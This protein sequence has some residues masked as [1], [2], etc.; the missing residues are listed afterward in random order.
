MRRENCGKVEADVEF[1]LAFCGKLSCSAE[2][3]C[4]KS[5]GDTQSTQSARFGKRICCRL[6]SVG[7]HDQQKGFEFRWI[8]KRGR[9]QEVRRRLLQMN[10]EATVYVI[11]LGKIL[12]NASPQGCASSFIA[13]KDFRWTRILIW[14]NQWSKNHISIKRDSNT[15]QHGELRF[16]SWGPGLSA[17]F[18]SI[19]SSSTPMTLLGQ[20]IDHSKSSSSSSTSTT[21]TSSKE[22]DHS[23]HFQ[24]SCQAIVWIDKNGETRILLKHQKSCRINQPKSQNPK[25]DSHEQVLGDPYYSDIPEWF[26]RIQR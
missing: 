6:P 17:S 3:E 24:Q 14:V 13:R 8:G 26:P 12:D 23:D 11:E 15:V 5:S 20:E 16:R 1:G 7:A 19:L 21:V 10:E 4:I 9:H 22:T 25:N 2:F 18:F